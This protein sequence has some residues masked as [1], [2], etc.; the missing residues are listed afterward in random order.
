LS[1]GFQGEDLGLSVEA[2]YAKFII[3]KNIPYNKCH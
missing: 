1:A 3:I 2:L